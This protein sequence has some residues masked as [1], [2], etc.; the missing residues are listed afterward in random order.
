MKKINLKVN[1]LSINGL[2]ENPDANKL[3][4]FVHGF[5]GNMHGPADIFDKLSRKLQNMNFG[6]LRFNFRG[7]PPSGGEFQ[8]MTVATETQDLKEIIKYAKFLGYSEIGLLGESMGGTIAL[9]VYDQSMKILVL[10]YPAL[11]FSDSA[12]KDLFFIKSAQEEILNKGYFLEDGFKIGKNFIDQVFSINVFDNLEKINCPVLILH[13]DKDT[14]IPVA[15]SKK[16][17]QMLREPKEFKIIK[18]AE[19]CF[20]QEQEEAIDLTLDFIRR[21]F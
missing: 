17:Y 5:T 18:G 11:D 21:F 9:K 4:I 2:I 10:W 14:E 7:T 8:D 20:K 12:F 13:G 1:S 6:V 19:H 16:A 3:M 15:Q